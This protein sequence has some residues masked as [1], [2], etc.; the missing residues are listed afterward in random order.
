MP[1]RFP[2]GGARYGVGATI[3]ARRSAR[4]ASPW[5]W[6]MAGTSTWR[7][8]TSRALASPG[9]TGRA[10]HVGNRG[11]SRSCRARKSERSRRSGL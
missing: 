1:V 7:C 10:L 4:D 5:R 2:P 3:V 9:D 6:P 11:S 8:A